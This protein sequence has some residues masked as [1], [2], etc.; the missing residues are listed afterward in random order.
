VLRVLKGHGLRRGNSEDEALDGGDL[1]CA[2]ILALGVG[3]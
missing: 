3:E 2:A 1:H